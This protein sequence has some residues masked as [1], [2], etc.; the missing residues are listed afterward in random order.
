MKSRQWMGVVVACLGGILAARGVDETTFGPVIPA[1]LKRYYQGEG[2]APP[3]QA[4]VKLLGEND[5]A[6]AGAAANYLVAL[7]NQALAD[8]TSGDSP[9]RAT[10]YWGGGG[11]NPARNLREYLLEAVSELDPPTAAVPVLEWFI[12]QDPVTVHRATAMKSLVKSGSPEADA[13]VLAIAA[14]ASLSHARASTGGPAGRRAAA[15]GPRSRLA[16]RDD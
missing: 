4:A 5:S 14:D 2:K 16:G 3:W 10:P 8:E 13:L 7:S 11:E 9:W 12:R 1:E 15:R 6:K